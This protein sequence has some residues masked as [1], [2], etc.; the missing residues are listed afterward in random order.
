MSPGGRVVVFYSLL[1]A[2]NGILK[3]G[4]TFLKH[5]FGQFDQL[6]SGRIFPGRIVLV[7]CRKKNALSSRVDKFLSTGKITPIHR[8]EKI[9]PRKRRV[10]FHRK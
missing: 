7:F 10:V 8:Q 6:K 4:N 5:I 9:T 1:K 2:A 3:V